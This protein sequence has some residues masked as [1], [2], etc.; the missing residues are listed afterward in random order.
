ML[1]NRSM[2][3][4]T[5]I[6][7]LVYDDV[8][9]AIDWLCRTFGFTERWRAGTHRA[10]LAFGAGAIVVT[11]AREGQG[12]EDQA[13]S[14][15]LRQPRSGEV[16]HSVMVRVEDVDAHYEHA[17]K[18]GARIL[19]P[20]TDYPYGERQYEVEDLAGRRWSFS[21]SIADVAPEEWGGTSRHLT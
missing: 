19:H 6:P 17:K 2:P 4:A 18:C 7:E 1:T 11:E 20:P 9:E 5:V 21:Q 12:W 8:A 14:A 13:D 10:Q 15:E 16:S 3:S